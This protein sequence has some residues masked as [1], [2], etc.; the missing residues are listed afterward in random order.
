MRTMCQSFNCVPAHAFK[1]LAEHQPRSRSR[2]C[3]SCDAACNRAKNADPGL[4]VAN[5]RIVFQLLPF[6]KPVGP[7]DRLI[8][9]H[10]PAEV[11]HVIAPF[12]GFQTGSTLASSFGAT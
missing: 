12:R 10:D 3:R 5:T 11:D 8:D 9:V 2:R 6:D 1:R 4:R 7:V